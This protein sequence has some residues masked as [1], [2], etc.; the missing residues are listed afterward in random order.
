MDSTP[1]NPVDRLL[2]PTG[3]LDPKSPLNNLKPPPL[4]NGKL[5]SL[6]N[7]TVKLPDEIRISDFVI[8]Y[9]KENPAQD[10]HLS[11]SSLPLDRIW[12]KKIIGSNLIPKECRPP[13]IELLDILDIHFSD[14]DL[15]IMSQAAPLF[16][17]A[18]QINKGT[19]VSTFPGQ[20]FDVDIVTCSGSEP[21][22]LT[23]T[24]GLYISLREWMEKGSAVPRLAGEGFFGEWLLHRL[25]KIF[26]VEKP[27][28][29]GALKRLVQFL[30]YGYTT[31]Q[32]G[33]IREIVDAFIKKKPRLKQFISYITERQGHL[34]PSPKAKLA[35]C[36]NVISIIVEYFPPEKQFD[37]WREAPSLLEHKIKKGLLFEIALY[38]REF[39]YGCEYLI[40]TLKMCSLLILEGGRAYALKDDLPVIQS[41]QNGQDY[42]SLSLGRHQN[43]VVHFK[44]QPDELTEKLFSIFKPDYKGNDTEKRLDLLAGM[45]LKFMLYSLA[46]G[47][48]RA[49]STHE[50]SFPA[51]DFDSLN[52]HDH[53]ILHFIR[54]FLAILKNQDLPDES[55][56]MQSLVPSLLLLKTG[57]E[58]KLLLNHLKPFAPSVTDNFIKALDQKGTLDFTSIHEVLISCTSRTSE[59]EAF[60][61]WN[62]A[63]GSTEFEM[64]AKCRLLAGLLNEKRLSDALDDGK[65]DPLA[66]FKYLPESYRPKVAERCD[67]NPEGDINKGWEIAILVFPYIDRKKIPSLF[68]KLLANSKKHAKSLNLAAIDQKNAAF[69]NLL[70]EAE[71][72]RAADYLIRLDRLGIFPDNKELW[73]STLHSLTEVY[74]KIRKEKPENNLPQLKSVIEL[75]SKRGFSPDL[76]LLQSR[77]IE[78]LI[79][80]KNFSEAIFEIT[81][82]ITKLPEEEA[83]KE[84]CRWIQKLK[85]EKGAVLSLWNRY[86]D[87]ISG[88]NRIWTTIFK[89]LAQEKMRREA[90]N[91]LTEKETLKLDEEAGITDEIEKTERWIWLFSLASD[92]NG[93]IFRDMQAKFLQLVKRDICDFQLPK[94]EL[95][96]AAYK[97]TNIPNRVMNK[98]EITKGDFLLCQLRC[99]LVAKIVMGIWKCKN[100]NK[101]KLDILGAILWLKVKAQPKELFKFPEEPFKEAYDQ[102]LLQNSE[103]I[104]KSMESR[105]KNKTLAERYN[106]L[107][108]ETHK[109]MTYFVRGF[110]SMLVFLLLTYCERFF[111]QKPAF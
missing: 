6:L 33:I 37:Y 7:A 8:K 41:R 84:V 99:R 14:I 108:P 26:Y 90:W 55:K 91:L 63:A 43:A 77:E 59:E 42:L 36:L 64:D 103:T 79:N 68:E 85:T 3:R 66:I 40:T 38:L 1:V 92:K 46:N 23:T 65:V 71:P 48:G 95:C 75:W 61:I 94:K 51:Q 22:H 34:P 109:L 62:Q 83:E 15:R 27:L 106:N 67:W 70:K 2:L 45:L 97:W 25:A 73:R 54:L 16:K 101:Q 52:A 69:W 11:G 76:R 107:S 82:L 24:D 81:S 5:E 47:K 4:D 89:V 20:P 50:L 105:P 32:P 39:P 10:I 18:H 57:N 98:I 93:A 88:K 80:G 72:L 49:A 56:F 78:N 60:H 19:W 31:P 104:Y 111:K 87:K 35:F 110:L 17:N 30:T 53:P 21:S 58:Q 44:H 74:K 13:L 29:H 100:V 28:N 102:I 86:R 96:L 9:L 12:F